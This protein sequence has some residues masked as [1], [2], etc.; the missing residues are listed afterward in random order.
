MA[1]AVTVYN[2]A[3]EFKD[4]VEK[5]IA[6]TKE[7]LGEH[8]KSIEEIRKKYEKTKKRYDTLKKLTGKAEVA[9]D[10]KQLDVG[11]FKV[12]VNPT[13]DYELTLMEEA[14]TS[15]QEKLN[16]FEKAKEMFPALIDESMKV[17]VVLN[18]GVPTGF[19]LYMQD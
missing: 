16:L 19:M 11:G 4:Y 5:T 15:L 6:Q 17:G 13:A 18:D 9:K 1:I 2:S 14:I 12:L 7:A 3:P 8:M 10:T